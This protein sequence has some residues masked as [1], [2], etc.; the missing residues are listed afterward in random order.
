MK[1]LSFADSLNFRPENL[2]LWAKQNLEWDV[3][4]KKWGSR[5]VLAKYVRKQEKTAPHRLDWI[6]IIPL[7][8]G[9]GYTPRY[10]KCDC[11]YEGS[12]EYF[13]DLELRLCEVCA[14]EII[15]AV[16]K[17]VN[18]AINHREG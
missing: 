10:L 5:E 9:E 16:K 18:E 1:K 7:A 15:R 11:G 8:D 2:E 4:F 13:T 14:E 12:E 3:I 17:A 6:P